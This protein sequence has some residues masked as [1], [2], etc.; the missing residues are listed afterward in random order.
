MPGNSNY[1]LSV[2]NKACSCTDLFIHRAHT[3]NFE[4][5]DIYLCVSSDHLA[6]LMCRYGWP[7]RFQNVSF[8]Y[9]LLIEFKTNSEVLDGNIMSKM[10]HC[11]SGWT[12]ICTHAMKH[13]RQKSEKKINRS[14]ELA[15]YLFH[16]QC[17]MW[18]AYRRIRSVIKTRYMVSEIPGSTSYLLWTD[19]RESI[20]EMI[21]FLI[22]SCPKVSAVLYALIDR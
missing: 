2:V 15:C 14:K 12:V 3:V 4:Y 8:F 7:G 10:C 20:S 9:L 21:I 6:F 22:G 13:A 5:P 16:V 17:R 19:G 18:G 11:E 1:L